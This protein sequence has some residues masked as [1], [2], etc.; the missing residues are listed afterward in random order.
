TQ[1]VTALTGRERLAI[2]VV[3]GREA[4]GGVGKDGKRVVDTT[5]EALDDRHGELDVPTG[6]LG[7]DASP[8]Q[9]RVFSD[10][11]W[12]GPAIVDD[13]ADGD[14][15]EEWRRR[16]RDAPECDLRGGEALAGAIV[17]A[18]R[19]RQEAGKVV[20]DDGARP[21]GDGP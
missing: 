14:R 4:I 19:E 7:T 15:R 20:R 3:D 10:R 11:E 5:R 13:P 8:E 21:A 16:G 1:R 2:G 9:H 6:L 12:N 18:D 17:I